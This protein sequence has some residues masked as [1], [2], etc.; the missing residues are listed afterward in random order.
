[1]FYQGVTATL[2]RVLSFSLISE[3][4]GEVLRQYGETPSLVAGGNDVSFQTPIRPPHGPHHPPPDVSNKTIYQALQDDDRFSRLFKFVNTSELVSTA[5]N[6]TKS[7]VTF[8]AAPNSALQPPK[9][10][11]HGHELLRDDDEM[12]IIEEIKATA[13]HSEAFAMLEGLHQHALKEGDEDDEHKKK[14]FKK[15]VEAVLLYH[16][17]PGQLTG[18]DLSKNTTFSTSLV[19]HDG[20]LDGEPER[21]RVATVPRKLR[22]TLSINFFTHVVLP[23]IK[24]KNGLI[25]VIDSP[26][27]PPPSAFQTLFILSDIFSTFTSALQRVGLSDEVEWRWVRGEKGE[28]GSLQGAPVVT[29]FVPTNRAFRQLPR[30]LKL[31][32]FSPF[33]ERVLKKV[34]QF[35]IAPDFAL[36]SDWSLNVTD[37]FAPM[38]ENDLWA[39]PLD[40]DD[41]DSVEEGD[42]SSYNSL[43]DEPKHPHFPPRRPSPPNKHPHIPHPEPVY[44][45]NVSLPTL[46]KDRHLHVGIVQF[47][48]RLPLPP[49]KQVYVSKVF[50]NGQPV[51]IPD[52]VARNGAVHVI[53]RVINPVKHH[54]GDH[55]GHDE[56]VD[57]PEEE[58]K[59]WEDWLVE[60]ANNSE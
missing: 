52:V 1:M 22:P 48:H 36:H 18:E 38:F 15:I 44:S 59:G 47:E 55:G 28:R 37:S 4:C 25:H 26:L 7:S 29:V 56:F 40:C 19:L 58:W 5:L 31:F 8:F 46:L 32:L 54:H 57:D 21:I 51:G 35:H 27:F 10:P 9:R 33:G 11:K 30:K 20:S 3:Q 43:A 2:C 23:N 6:D 24:A 17:L 41:L 60:W 42:F 53:G 12:S 16:I 14:V 13:D 39:Q 49:H 50:V 45:Q 34:L